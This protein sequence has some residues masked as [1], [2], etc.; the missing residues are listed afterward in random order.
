MAT[1]NDSSETI[2]L[3]LE[4]QDLLEA[5]TTHRRFL[6]TTAD[7]LTDSQARQ[8]STVSDLTVG[9][10]IKH[11]AETEQAWATFMAGGEL[12]G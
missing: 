3:S 4:R 10:I 8:R 11:V 9:G 12:P 1:T 6:R 7:G 5:L 2:V